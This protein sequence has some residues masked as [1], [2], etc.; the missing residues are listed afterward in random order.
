MAAVCYGR[1]L[2]VFVFCVIKVD[3]ISKQNGS[4]KA[5]GRNKKGKKDHHFTRYKN[6]LLG[7]GEQSKAIKVNLATNK[8]I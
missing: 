2:V 5:N 7:I 6:C 8:Y 3:E 1:V 4:S